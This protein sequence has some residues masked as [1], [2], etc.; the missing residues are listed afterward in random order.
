MPA[1]T[2]ANG[3]RDIAYQLI[4]REPG[5]SFQVIFGGG[6][7]NFKPKMVNAT[8]ANG[9]AFRTDG[10]DLIQQWKDNRVASG[11]SADQFAYVETRD[12]LAAL[13]ANKVQF[14][15]GLFDNDHVVY[16][17]KRHEKPEEP[18]LTE[19]SLKAV[20]LLSR[21]E[22]GFVLLVE[23]GRIDHAHHENH[24]VLAVEDMVE[25]DH[26]VGKVLTKINQDE[27]LVVVTADHSH[28]F[29]INGY[30]ERGNSIFG[31]TGHVELATNK[32]F[33][34]LMYGNGPGHK[35]VRPDALLEDTGK[36]LTLIRP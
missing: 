32:S 16:H 5:N 17:A 36:R 9:D 3:C 20:E 27:T 33:T 6:R 30:P 7:R 31:T 25:F 2:R 13:D 14:A 34:T 26:A 19:M 29:V 35:E 11:L 15:F 4:N 10:L 18:T 12:Q 8:V 28:T 1:S 23:G 24:G 22:N 21:H